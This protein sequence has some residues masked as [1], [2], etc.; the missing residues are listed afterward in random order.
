MWIQVALKPG[1]GER[2]W[3]VGSTERRQSDTGKRRGK[4][5]EREEVGTEER[6]GKTRTEHFKL[7]Q[8]STVKDKSRGKVQLKGTSPTFH[9]GEEGAAFH[10]RVQRG[11]CS[12]HWLQGSTGSLRLPSSPESRQLWHCTLRPHRR[13]APG[14]GTTIISARDQIS[15]QGS[16]WLKPDWRLSLHGRAH[17]HL[18]QQGLKAGRHPGSPRAAGALPL[19]PALLR[20]LQHSCFRVSLHFLHISIFLRQM[21]L[22]MSVSSASK[23]TVVCVFKDWIRK[24]NG[25]DGCPHLLGPWKQTYFSN[26]LKLHCKMAPGELFIQLTKEG[27]REVG[28]L[29]ISNLTRPCQDEWEGKGRWLTGCPTPVLAAK[30]TGG[31]GNAQPSFTLSYFACFEKIKM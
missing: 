6:E 20:L 30:E 3:A 17:S 18:P 10:T 21:D 26:A 19:Q 4:E 8:N 29:K 22:P 1:G 24:A 9:H 7:T 27:G 25:Y 5:G 12:L 2:R 13:I 15:L 28:T 31:V 14:A 11:L 16:A 23:Y